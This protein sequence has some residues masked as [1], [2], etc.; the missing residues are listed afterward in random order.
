MLVKL[1]EGLK[2][3]MSSVGEGLIHVPKIV[4]EAVFDALTINN[5][6]AKT[7]TCPDL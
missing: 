5:K 3:F 1:H 7:T 6:K 2:Q 4:S